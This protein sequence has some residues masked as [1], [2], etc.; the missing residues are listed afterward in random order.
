MTMQAAPALSDLVM[1]ATALV[2][3]GLVVAV[4]VLG[5]HRSRW[6]LRM[7]ALLAVIVAAYG[8]VLFGVGATSTPV[9]LGRGE[10]K[11]FDDWCVA[12]SSARTVS[13]GTLA[14]EVQ[15]QNRARRQPMRSEL[16]R[17]YVEVPGSP[18]VDPVNGAV[19]QVLLP[20]GGRAAEELRFPA[21]AR[22]AGAR[23]VVTESAG[24]FGPAQFAIGSEASPLHA[25]AGWPLRPV[26][27]S[28]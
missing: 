3:L 23:F 10:A 7:G 25:S 21:P 8:G 9:Q 12:L 4:T 11:C 24:G 18:P 13:G 15:V 17:A 1:L 5:L 19:L 28:G 27:M 26:E 22:A 2:V 6:G 16:A 14:I 20:P